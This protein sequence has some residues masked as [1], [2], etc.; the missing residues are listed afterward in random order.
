MSGRMEQRI[1]TSVLW[2][3]TAVE[4][5]ELHDDDAV[6]MFETQAHSDYYLRELINSEM[7]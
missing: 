3:D 6:Q 2:V 4:F 7:W 1:R 5:L